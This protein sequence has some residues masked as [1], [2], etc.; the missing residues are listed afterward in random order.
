ME[1]QLRDLK[2]NL[3]TTVE[4]METSNEE[5]KSTNEELQSTNEELQSTNEELETSK[6]EL[7]SMNEESITVNI[8]LQ[9]RIDELTKSNDDMKNLLDST[10]I[11]TIFLDTEMQIRRFTPSVRD[12]IPLTITDIGRPIS[13]FAH[14]LKMKNLTELAIKVLDTLGKSEYEINSED[15]K[16]YL[17][18]M[19]PYRTTSNVIDGVVITFDDITKRKTAE[20]GLLEAQTIAKMGSWSWELKTKKVQLSDNLHRTLDLEPNS[21]DGKVDS[22]LHLI[23]SED[24]EIVRRKVNEMIDTQES[25]SFEFRIVGEN[26]TVKTVQCNQK[27]HY[28]DQG[29]LVRI[30][31]TIQDITERKKTEDDLLLMSKVFMDSNDPIIIKD[32]FGNIVDLNDEAE[33]SYGWNRKELMGKSIKMLIPPNHHDQADQLIAQ[34]KNGES[35]RNVEDE[36]WNKSKKVIPVLVTLSLLKDQQ[37]IPI[38]IATISKDITERKQHEIALKQSEERHRLLFENTSLGI[39]YYDLNGV[40]VAYN[41]KAAQ[42]M[43]GKPD[44]FQGKKLTDLF[45]PAAGAEYMDRILKASKSTDSQTYED[46]VYLPTGTYQFISTLNKVL[47][48]NGEVIGVQITATDIS[49]VKEQ[50]KTSEKNKLHNK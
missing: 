3:Q 21:F 36:R 28:H 37:G 48:A 10:Q 39:G 41:P 47:N 50:L 7:Q 32:L 19:L 24:V 30:I 31:G 11:A 15:G 8:E 42:N 44:D 16:I 29:H 5:L 9:N 43:G 25:Q 33:E 49:K 22:I 20:D 4:E 38:G 34:C 14:N 27:L 35:V 13:H 26:R 46:T 45:E 17:T 12:I 40:I 23:H 1:L 6:E 18:R 2:E